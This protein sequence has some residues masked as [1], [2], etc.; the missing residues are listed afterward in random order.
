MKTIKQSTLMILALLVT[1]ISFSQSNAGSTQ[2]PAGK[3]VMANESTGAATNATAKTISRRNAVAEIIA[4]AT[5]EKSA[6]ATTTKTSEEKDLREKTNEINREKDKAATNARMNSQA[7]LHASEQAKVHANKNAA[8]FGEKAKVKKDTGPKS[9]GKTK[10]K[11]GK[12]KGATKPGTKKNTHA[13]IKDA[14]PQKTTGK[15]KKP[16]AKKP[17]KANSAGT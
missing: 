7:T 3:T 17:M 13:K 8:V 14:K 11:P 15:L 1:T 10:A 9:A 12:T 4:K 6:T 16:K 5:E 2:T